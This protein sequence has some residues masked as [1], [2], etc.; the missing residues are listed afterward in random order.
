VIVPSSVI[1][2][3][4]EEEHEV[5]DTARKIIPHKVPYLPIPPFTRGNP[6]KRFKKS[7]GENDFHL[8][9]V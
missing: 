5:L 2:H 9:L 6:V 1:P 3:G 4:L 8:G 7:I